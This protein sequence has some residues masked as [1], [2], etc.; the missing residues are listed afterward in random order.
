MIAWAV[1]PKFVPPPIPPPN[2]NSETFR[3]APLISEAPKPGVEGMMLLFVVILT[4]FGGR[5][6]LRPL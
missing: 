6:S 2:P 1:P 4:G 5:A 3:G